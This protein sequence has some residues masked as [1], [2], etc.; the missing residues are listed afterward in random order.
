MSNT[1]GD[2]AGE[3]RSRSP[4][5]RRRL[6]QGLASLLA[7][8]CLALVLGAEY[9]LRHAEP[10]LR[11]RIVET[12]SARFHAPVELDELEISL[13]KGIEVDGSG[14]RIG[15]SVAGANG[16]SVGPLPPLLS[17]A[18]FAFR[19]SFAGL[20]RQP[21]HVDVVRVDGIELQVPPAGERARLFAMDETADAKDP[22]RKTKIAIVVQQ[23]ECRDVTVFLEPGR[24]EGGKP[25]LEFDIATLSLRGIGA[26]GAMPFEARF[27]NPKPVGAIEVVGHF[28]PW[29]GA[30]VGDRA[31]PDAGQ[32]PIDG[33][34]SFDGADLSTIRGIG[35]TLS[36]TGHFAGVLDRIAI[37]GHTETPNFSL[38]IS[39][40]PMPLHTEFHAVVDGTSG[41]TYLEPVHARLAGSEFTTAGKIVKVKGEGHDIQLEVD[42]PHGRMQDFLRLAVKTDPPLLNGVLTMRA[43]L[44]IPPGRERVAEKMSMAGAFSVAGVR[45]NNARWQ[46][47]I[48]GLSARAQGR[49]GDVGQVSRDAEVPSQLAANFAM[50]HGVMSMTDLRYTVPGA[51]VLLNG[52]YSNDG[53]LFEFK[54]HVRTAAT[55]SQMVGGWKGLLLSPFDHY[56]QR[57]GAGLELPVEISGTQGDVH[58]GLVTGGATPETPSQLLADVRG[59]AKAKVEMN[60]ARNYAAEA[61]AQDALAARAPTLEAAERAHAAAVRLRAEAQREALAAGKG[62]GGA[63]H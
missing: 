33:Q 4:W 3:T 39:N 11:K 61:A 59:K 46:S 52:V 8:V 50:A 49:P 29:G 26:G 15:S 20:L 51:A 18:H 28:G 17:V 35:G 30:P 24:P 58:L 54:G 5:W 12:L 36:S 44:H 55:A 23:L 14:L 57:N 60:T 10:I 13:F 56:L 34:Y 21:T 63:S 42:I 37:D 19:T 22:G 31:T 41:D 32:T 38:D 7:V 16:A 40:R 9:V 48:D 45:F 1:Y 2:V 47:R 6:V 43:R 27:T 53:R 25:P 62:P